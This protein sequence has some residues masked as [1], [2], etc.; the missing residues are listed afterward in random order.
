MRIKQEVHYTLVMLLNYFRKFPK[1]VYKFHNR[2]GWRKAKNA[3]FFNQR[4][5]FVKFWRI[6]IG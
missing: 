4:I 5:C 2:F 6:Q 3:H 1:V